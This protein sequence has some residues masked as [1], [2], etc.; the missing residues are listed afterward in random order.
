MIPVELIRQK[1]YPAIVDWAL[2]LKEMYLRL[3]KKLI[4]ILYSLGKMRTMRSR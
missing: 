4:I 2:A 1:D 3:Y